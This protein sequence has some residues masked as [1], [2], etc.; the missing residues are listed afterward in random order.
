MWDKSGTFENARRG[1]EKRDN[2][3]NP[4]LINS[5]LISQ[6]IESVLL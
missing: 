5:Q 3:D 6:L 2:P 1:S 4:Q